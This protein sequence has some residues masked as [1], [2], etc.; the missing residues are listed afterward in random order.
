MRCET[1]ST[2][3]LSPPLQFELGSMCHGGMWTA[4]EVGVA[5]PTEVARLEEERLCLRRIR[6]ADRESGWVVWCLRGCWEV[7]LDSGSTAN[8]VS[9][10][11]G[12][13]TSV[14]GDR[15]EGVA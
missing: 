6:G 12:F 1:L 10:E 14:V 8:R 7:P 15:V 5:G 4:G 11:N 3:F 9:L 2:A 13:E